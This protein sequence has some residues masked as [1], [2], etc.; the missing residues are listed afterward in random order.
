MAKTKIKEAPD[1]SG[2]HK[3]YLG[4]AVL[5][6][7]C[8]IYTLIYY[9]TWN[10]YTCV[11]SDPR[12]LEAAIMGGTFC[13]NK[14]N[15]AVIKALYEDYWARVGVAIED[16]TGLRRLETTPNYRNLQTQEEMD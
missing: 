9:F 16:E 6:G 8:C 11:K 5:F 2:M 12:E 10:I 14:N 13:A 4:M 3:Y 1:Y 7:A 15:T